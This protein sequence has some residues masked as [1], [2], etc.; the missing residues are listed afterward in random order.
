M[1]WNEKDVKVSFLL[2]LQMILERRTNQGMLSLIEPKD[3]GSSREK[4]AVKSNKEGEKGPVAEISNQDRKPQQEKTDE[5]NPVTSHTGV[6]KPVTVNTSSLPAVEK[7][8]PLASPG[9]V[10]YNPI[11]HAPSMTIRLCT[12]RS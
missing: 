3:G 1:Y 8:S 11:T 2:Y 6:P 7:S 10:T 9:K 4:P 5:A 12:V